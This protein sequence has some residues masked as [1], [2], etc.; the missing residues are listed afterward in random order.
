MR[1]VQNGFVR[2]YALSVLLG[3]GIYDRI[4]AVALMS[5]PIVRK[6]ILKT[7]TTLERELS[8]DEDKHELSS[9]NL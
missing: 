6:Q 2:S 7:L 1:R 8:Q 9:S 4:F 5:L 3:V